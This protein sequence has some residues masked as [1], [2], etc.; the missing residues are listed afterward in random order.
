MG[1]RIPVDLEEAV[2]IIVSGLDAES[3]RALRKMNA[4]T[5]RALGHHGIGQWIRNAWGLWDNDGPL[6]LWFVEN[7]GLHHADDISNVIVHCV[8]ADLSENARDVDEVVQG[9]RDHWERQG[10]RPDG[11]KL[12]TDAIDLLNAGVKKP[13]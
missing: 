4:E 6:F 1:D 10:R 9:M 3:F 7:F 8:W 5:A 13:A 12:F 11:T 2:T